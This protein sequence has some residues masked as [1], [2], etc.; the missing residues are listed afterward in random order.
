MEKQIK[1]AMDRRR[2]L[3][4]TG[5]VGASALA[6]TVCNKATENTG[7]MPAGSMDLGRAIPAS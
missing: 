1:T 5:M 3:Q 6:L 2:F 4:F 7:G